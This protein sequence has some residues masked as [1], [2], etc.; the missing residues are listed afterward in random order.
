MR[1]RVEIDR[2]SEIFRFVARLD[3]PMMRQAAAQGLN[4]HAQEQRRQAVTSMVRMTGVPRGRVSSVTK[5]ARAR[6]AHTMEARVTVADKAIGL[7]EYGAP[8][9]VRDLTPGWRGGAV[10]SMRGAEATGWNR[11]KT[12]S[13]AFVAKGKVFIRKSDG[14]HPLKM[15]S[16]PVLANELADKGKSTAPGAIRYAEMDMTRR[17]LRHVGIALGL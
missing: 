10:S 9:W 14:R 17:V 16:G 7:H 2:N 11:R 4:E 6:P 12:Y 15:L 3:S 1:V 8:S 5:V 13:G